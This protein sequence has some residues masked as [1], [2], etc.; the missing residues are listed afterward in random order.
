MESERRDNLEFDDLMFVAAYGRLAAVKALL[1]ADADV[2][3]RSN[4]HGY[5]ALILATVNN[6]VEVVRHF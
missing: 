6:H 2:T 5:T 1:A 4:I 3:G